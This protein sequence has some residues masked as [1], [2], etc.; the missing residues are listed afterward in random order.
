MI[1]KDDKP[2]QK[3]V[4]RI[5]ETKA[6]DV[7]PPCS[8]DLKT[9]FIYYKLRSKWPL[10]NDT[11]GPQYQSLKLKKFTLISQ[12]SKN[13]YCSTINGDIIKIFN[14]SYHNKLR[15]E[16]IIG[17][18]FLSKENLFTLP[19]LSSKLEIY[20]VHTLSKL[21]TWTI[22]SSHRFKNLSVSN[23]KKNI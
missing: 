19:C 3:I 16:V 12:N 1:K 7:V 9:N 10:I 11:S 6:N 22:S 18:T 5:Y 20:E 17:R 21:A 15:C 13:Q 4:R 23:S 2:L 14:I 8:C